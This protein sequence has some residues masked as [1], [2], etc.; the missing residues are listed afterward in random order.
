[1]SQVLL[2]VMVGP[3]AARVLLL[4]EDIT[5]GLTVRVDSQTYTLPRGNAQLLVEQLQRF[6]DATAL[7]PRCGHG[8]ID[9]FSLW[10]AGG[11]LYGCSHGTGERWHLA[12]GLPCDCPGIPD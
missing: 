3:K 10:T 1:M 12:G 4:G 6:L 7:C 2:D 8:R 9:H 5:G 11:R